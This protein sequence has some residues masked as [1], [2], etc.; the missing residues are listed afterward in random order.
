MGKSFDTFG[1]I[2]PWLVSVDS[3]DDPADLRLVTAVN[4][5]I[6]QD[7]T[8]A[9][10]IFDVPTL[11]SYLSHITTLTVGDIIFTGTP[12]GVGA[13]QGNFLADGDVITTTIDGIGTITNCCRRSTD[14]R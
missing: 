11:I 14:Y 13:S 7:D 1:P 6:R 3:V 9:S 2:G 5:E 12:E 10:L 4:G 8:T